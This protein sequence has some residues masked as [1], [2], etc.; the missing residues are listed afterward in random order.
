VTLPSRRPDVLVAVLGALACVV[1]GLAAA[2]RDS[3]SLLL[4]AGACGLALVI[5]FQGVGLGALLGWI[6]LS[7]PLYPVLSTGATDSPVGFDRLMVVGMASWLVMRRP[8][9]QW[10]P[11]ARRLAWAL[12]WLLVAFGIRAALTTPV[13]IIPLTEGNARIAA[14]NTW[15]DAILLPVLLYFVVARFA[16]TRARCLQIAGAM[17]IAGSVL[18]MI[19][20]A[21]KVIGFELASY[22]GGTA[23]VDQAIDV[24]RTA[25]PYSVPEVYAV[26][27]LVCL[28]ATLWW[29]LVRGRPV[30]PVGIMA[31]GLQLAGLGVTLFRAALIGAILILV[32]AFGLRPGRVLRVAVVTVLAGIVLALGYVQLQ[33]NRVLEARLQNTE[34]I[35]GRLATYAQGGELFGRNPLTG[36]GVGQFANAQEAVE[37]TV[38][39]GVEAATSP[40]STF[41]GLAAEQGILGFLPLIACVVAIWQLLGALRRQARDHAEV[42]LWS[43]LVGICL[44]YLVMSLTLSMLPYGPSNAFFAIALGLAAAT[45]NQRAAAD[46]RERV[47]R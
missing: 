31:V 37:L 35:K 36:V 27:L 41:V 4:L 5:V 43:C 6:V 13:G 19:G 24:V 10:S 32:A 33:D 23:R 44:A 12:G 8:G 9:L 40:H 15:I 14:V 34:N 30:Y 26:V 22:S 2:R 25:G 45:V 42:L 39:D 21:Q 16:D 47:R 20:V 3:M 29:M 38:V 7:G 28:G 11:A 1:V 17:A 18:G 46:H